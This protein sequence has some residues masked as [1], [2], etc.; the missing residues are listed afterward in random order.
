M[1]PIPLDQLPPGTKARVVNVFAPGRWNY[2][3]L[4]MGVVPGGLLEVV[5][6]N[7]RGPIVIRVMGVTLSL[8]RGIARRIF[9]EPLR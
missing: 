1:S 6:N 9:V 5:I 4:Q 2:R 7:G 3:L 8:G